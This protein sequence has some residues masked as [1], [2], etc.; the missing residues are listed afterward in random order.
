[1]N[2]FDKMLGL[3]GE[4]KVHYLDGEYQIVEPGEY[5]RCAVS[6]QRIPLQDLRYWNVARQE[7]YASAQISLQRY[8]ELRRSAE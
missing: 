8:L 7:P 3:K 6:G 4:A 1:M 2:R 5:V